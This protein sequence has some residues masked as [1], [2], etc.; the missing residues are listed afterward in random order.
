MIGASVSGNG[1]FTF[2]NSDMDS[3]DGIPK[4]TG[5]VE[6]QVVGA[7]GLLDKLIQMGIVAEEQ[8][9]GARMMMGML[10]VPGDGPDTLNSKIEINDQGQILANGQRIQ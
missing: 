6:L 9:M 3:F 7:N 2:D 10:A 1:D 4:P 8:A 5:Y